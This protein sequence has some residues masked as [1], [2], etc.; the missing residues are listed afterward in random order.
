MNAIRC[1]AKGP[2]ASYLCG[3]NV[4]SSCE[5]CPTYWSLAVWANVTT[6]VFGASILQVGQEG[7]VETK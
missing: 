7:S 6:I 5:P 1:A 2:G 4:F 3:A